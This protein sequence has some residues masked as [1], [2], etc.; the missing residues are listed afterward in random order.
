[1]RD[2]RTVSV[3]LLLALAAVSAA[4]A[5]PILD[6]SRVS[7]QT[8]DNGFRLILKPEHQWGL[9][10]AGL[11]IRAGSFC[12]SDQNAGVAH[13]LEHL[14]FE[15][16]DASDTTRIA[17]AVEA[18]GGEISAH[19]TRDFTHLDVTVAAQYLPEVLTMLAK[20]AF[21]VQISPPVVARE[22]E[23]VARELTDRA[24]Y[25][26]GSLDDLVWATAFTTHPYRRPIGG[27][28]DQVLRLTEVEVTE[29]YQRFYVPGNMALVVVG[30]VDPAA[31]TAQVA[32]L[33]GSRPARSVALPQPA[34]EPPQT[35]IRSV[36]RTRPSDTVLFAYSW[37][38][39]GIAQPTDVCAMDLIYTLLGEGAFGRLYAALEEPG[40]ALMSYVQYLTQRF[41][42]LFTVTVLTTPD[43]D[44]KARGAVL[45]EIQRLRDQPVSEAELA[46][47]KRL[48]RLSYAFNNEAYSDQVRTL[49]FYEGLGDYRFALNYMDLIDAVTVEEIHRVARTYLTLDSYSLVVVRPEPKP[50]TTEEA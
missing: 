42:G 14:L 18:M 7:E 10:S 45:A 19:T 6:P 25:A 47:A 17:P 11:Y 13:L 1:M 46:Q 12:E 8:F 50:G 21:E 5:V 23:V 9:A 39:P 2:Y 44:L 43:N 49:G 32:E 27:S 38:A 28:P 36:I 31:V 35:E 37:H 3:V 20:A 15:A 40:L 41:P 34:A 26:E 33:F 16:T 48:L 29:F 22:R 24:E 4:A 30:D